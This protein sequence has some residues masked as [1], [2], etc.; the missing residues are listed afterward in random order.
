MPATARSAPAW[1]QMNH[2]LQD[3]S[4]RSASNAPCPSVNARKINEL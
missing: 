3:G 2:D 1:A 4:G